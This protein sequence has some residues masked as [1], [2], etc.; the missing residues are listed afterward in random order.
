LAQ[1]YVVQANIDKLLPAQRASA[2]AALAQAITEI[3]KSTVYAG[4][5]GTVKQFVLQPGDIINP[6]LRPA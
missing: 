3:D 2:E 4:V 6:I 1:R 5:N